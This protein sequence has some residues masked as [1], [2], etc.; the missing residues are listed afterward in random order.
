MLG[1]VRFLRV[2]L[3]RVRFGQVRFNRGMFYWVRFGWIIL[4]GVVHGQVNLDQVMGFININQRKKNR[5]RNPKN[6]Q[7]LKILKFKFSAF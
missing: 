6:Y 2:W 4:D 7:N 1:N 3:S 5:N